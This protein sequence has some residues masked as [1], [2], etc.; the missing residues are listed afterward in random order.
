VSNDLVA[1]AIDH[2]VNYT[3]QDPEPL[4]RPNWI[5][6]AIVDR[7]IELSRGKNAED[8]RDTTALGARSVRIALHNTL[9]L[10]SAS[11]ALGLVSVEA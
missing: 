4:A 8:T 9:E 5:T 11:Q 6:E 2:F 10:A 3:Q 1:Y 7:D